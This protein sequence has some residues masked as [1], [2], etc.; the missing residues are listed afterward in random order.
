MLFT[1]VSQ[2]T[3]L[4]TSSL[5]VKFDAYIDIISYYK[6]S[7]LAYNLASKNEMRVV[8][9]IYFLYSCTALCTKITPIAVM[10]L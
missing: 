8:D 9:S 2:I 10:L 3:Q 6:T 5:T 7:K 1:K 4:W